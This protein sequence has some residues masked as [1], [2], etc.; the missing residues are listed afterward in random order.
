KAISETLRIAP[1]SPLCEWLMARSFMSRH[2]AAHGA[3][4]QLT[5]HE[6]GGDRKYLARRLGGPAAAGRA[7]RVERFDLVAD[8]PGVPDRL[9]ARGHSQAH[10]VWRALSSRQRAAVQRVNADEIASEVVGRDPRQPEPLGHHARRQPRALDGSRPG[11]R[12]LSL[13]HVA[14][15]VAK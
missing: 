7:V 5:R 11:V 12:D 15:A 2:L 4:D 3:R 9:R 1:L 13:S 14:V 10:L 8:S 6:R